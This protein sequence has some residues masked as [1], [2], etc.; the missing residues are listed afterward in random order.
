MQEVAGLKESVVPMV[1]VLCDKMKEMLQ[2]NS[3]AGT[4]EMMR[5]LLDDFRKDFNV[6]VQRLADRVGIEDQ[7]NL[8]GTVLQERVENNM[9]YELHFYEGKYSRVPPDWRFPRCNTLSLW[10]QWWIGNDVRRIH[11][12]RNLTTRDVDHLDYLP[13]SESEKSGRPG[14]PPKNESGR[15]ANKTLSDIRYLMNQ[16]YEI[17]KEQGVLVQRITESS[18]NEMFRAVAPFIVVGAR[19]VQKMWLSVVREFR[20]RNKI[21]NNVVDDVAPEE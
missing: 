19:D 10:T 6:Q 4:V 11:P 2:E 9:S 21:T 15:K 3:E 12:L 5:A 1:D 17:A 20:N 18:V 7:N 16:L 8:A 14:P 13:L